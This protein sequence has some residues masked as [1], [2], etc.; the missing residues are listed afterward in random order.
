MRMR[1]VLGRNVEARRRVRGMDQPALALAMT[2]AG[3]GWSYSTV[4][5]VERAKRGTNAE[6]VI[7]LAAVLGCSLADLLAPPE[8]EQLEVGPMRMSPDFLRHWIREDIVFLIGFN[9]DGSPVLPDFTVRDR[10]FIPAATVTEHGVSLAQ[11]TS[12]EVQKLIEAE[13]RRDE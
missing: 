7:A 8:G 12:V 9:E 4:S 6:E 5:S 3:F 10:E 1:E 2:N 13:R 11:F